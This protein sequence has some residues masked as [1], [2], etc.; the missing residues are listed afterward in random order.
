MNRPTDPGAAPPAAAADRNARV[1]DLSESAFH[2]AIELHGTSVLRY[3]R[4]RVGLDAAED[5]TAETF[6]V[7]WQVR[8]SFDP[9]IGLSIGA[10]LL[11]V[12]TNVIARHGRAEARWL[13]STAY[14]THVTSDRSAATEAT[15]HL[16]G[17]TG[18]DASQRVT[19]I[20]C[21]MPAQQRDPL[22]LHILGE[23]SYEEIA[24]VM[25]VPIGTI[26]SRISR[27]RQ[28]LERSGR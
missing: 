15:D 7:A 5:V 12:A 8:S 14:A 19:T 25:N 10:W 27:A 11:G 16:D 28:K 22:L 13:K 3:V 9:A 20:L 21:R 1:G 23:L 2:E 18:R 6:A 26:R 17:I 4:S 24:A